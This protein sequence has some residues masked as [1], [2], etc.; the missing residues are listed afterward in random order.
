[1]K[2]NSISGLIVSF[3]LAILSLNA[4]AQ[5]YPTKNSFKIESSFRNGEY[6]KSLTHCNHTI[7]QF[8]HGK[9]K[10]ILLY[11][12]ALFFKMEN[13]MMLTGSIDNILSTE[14]LYLEELRKLDE[15]NMSHYSIGLSKLAHL[16]IEYGFQKEAFLK[17]D[18]AKILLTKY[19]NEA[20]LNEVKH[21]EI[22]VL[23]GLG[24]YNEAFELAEKQ[25]EYEFSK[26]KKEYDFTLASANSTLKGNYRSNYFTMVKRNF[27]DYLN[28]IAQIQ[29][30]Y[31]D[32]V[33][34]D[35][36]AK[37]AYEWIIDN[38]DEKARD[39]SAFDNRILV[40]RNYEMLH[41]GNYGYNF[42]YNNIVGSKAGL[43]PS[44]E[45]RFAGFS[46][47]EESEAVMEYEEYLARHYWALPGLKTGMKSMADGY[48]AKHHS[49]YERMGHNRDNINIIKADLMLIDKY[50]LSLDYSKAKGHVDTLLNKKNF[51]GTSFVPE[52]HPYRRILLLKSLEINTLL[53]LKNDAELRIAQLK[54]YD[55]KMLVK[56]SP[57]EIEDELFIATYRHKLL[58]DFKGAL[59]KFDN[60]FINNY[61]TTI[62]TLHHDHRFL[63]NEYIDLLTIAG[64]FDLA[65]DL[66]GK[67][68]KALYPYKFQN[69]NLYALQLIEKANLLLKSGGYKEAA[70]LLLESKTD[71]EIFKIISNKEF[72]VS[73][74]SDDFYR[75]L[76]RKHLIYGDLKSAQ[77]SMKNIGDFTDE[78][79]IE[80][81]MVY[82]SAGKQDFILDKLELIDVK[83]VENFGSENF[84]LLPIYKNIALI[85]AR[86]GEFGV[87]SKQTLKSISIAKETFGT[88]SY[89]YGD[90]SFLLGMVSSYFGDYKNSTLEF[91]KA[92]DIYYSIYGTKNVNYARS[93]SEMSLAR[94]YNNDV[95]DE[96]EED[97]M[98]ASN[99]VKLTIGNTS[100]ENAAILK[101]QAFF[102]LEK[103]KI[104]LAERDIEQS[105]QILT[106][107]GENEYKQLLAE[108]YRINAK[109]QQYNKEYRKSELSYKKALGYY[110]SLYSNN[111]HIEITQTRSGIAQLY[112][113][114]GDRKDSKNELNSTTETY[115]NYIGKYFSYLTESEKKEFWKKINQ[116]FEFYKTIAFEYNN[117]KEIE[118][119]YNNTLLTKGIL[120]SSTKNL[121][122]AISNSKDEGLKKT[123][124]EWSA[125]NQSLTHA[126]SMSDDELKDNNYDIEILQKDVDK[127]EKSLSEKSVEFAQ[128][129][130][131]TKATW[132]SVRAALKENEYAVEIIRY[133]KFNGRFSDSVVYKALIIG[134]DFSTPQVV[135]LMDG[136]KLD[137]KYLSYY[138]N[139]T[140][141]MKKDMVSFRAFYEP[142]YKVVGEKAKVFISLEGVYNLVNLEA[143]LLPT[144]GY[145]MDKNQIIVVS[146]TKDII[147][148]KDEKVAL[149]FKNKNA[150][151]FS[152][153][154]FYAQNS[155]SIS[156]NNVNPDHP[157]KQLPGAEKEGS[158][159][160]SIFK[161]NHWKSTNL[162]WD[163][164]DENTFKNIGKTPETKYSYIH[165]STHGFFETAKAKN[166]LASSL[167]ERRG[168][169]D[170]YLRAGLIV[171]NGGDVMWKA[172]V[173][174]YNAADGVLTAKEISLMNLNGVDLCVLSACETG[175]GDIASGEGVYGLQRAMLS[176]G[177]KMVVISLFKVDDVVT[178][179]FM[180]AMTSK[181]HET[182]N[183]RLA[184]EYA[185]KE[186]QKE[187]PEPIYWGAFILID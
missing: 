76:T 75:V 149:M 33:K 47:Y 113:V 22:E 15:S 106:D 97:F 134:K 48:Y 10:N 53:G 5:V 91:K 112:Y 130:T 61:N 128:E 74:T 151:I 62:H 173:L 80:F 44:L 14:T 158:I 73:S 120:L 36:L 57:N 153:P 179:K 17:I 51:L 30:N 181:F 50:F 164:A 148:K 68:I 185:K 8:E 178:Q 124:Q 147:A 89:Q 187:Y 78:D 176:A 150:L 144:G 95:S 59:S 54:E 135:D 3:F 24:Y 161:A 55:A 156:H 81:A 67:E 63:I 29:Y 46:Y 27:A 154:M 43:K 141:F 42:T 13:I 40:I 20:A 143:M 32:F 66:M 58:G 52:N 64:K 98:K 183:A 70:N 82:V 138:R 152:N 16:Y 100:F 163:K 87:A 1:M 6:Q 142:I 21:Y 94:L 170:P 139:T 25:K 11:T 123:F 49:Y 114:Q 121:R 77:K 177:V 160:D 101:N 174:N 9:L 122:E 172:D 34:S 60:L 79:Y 157:V 90:V 7:H 99:I 180:S 118:T 102:Y 119:V 136:N 184:M 83:Y 145:V 37:V 126:L 96:I 127:L 88:N 23:N 186:I 169:D 18:K 105:I 92:R 159:V 45:K 132:Q 133:N 165:V 108:N 167:D 115:L 39:V 26:I 168:I 38:I 28:L 162:A 131:S 69:T 2:S 85:E 84:R 12:H 155:T 111:E 65:N 125:K 93:I 146:S 31:G 182:E 166:T 171:K 137:D 104:D 35:S 86:K 4:V 107:L 117:K 116:D 56:D 175:L 129:K 71:G 140:K 109:I 103:G 19:P 41:Q 110:S 72:S